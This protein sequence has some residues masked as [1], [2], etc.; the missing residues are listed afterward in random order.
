MKEYDIDFLESE[1]ESFKEDLRQVLKS[2]P[3]HYVKLTGIS[4]QHISYFINKDRGMS[5]EKL[6]HIYKC[7]QADK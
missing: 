7:I 3:Q 4:K 6:K 2:N 5:L 1:L